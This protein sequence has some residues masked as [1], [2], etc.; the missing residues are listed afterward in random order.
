MS[1]P[2][3]FWLTITNIVLGGLVIALVVGIATG[4]L[5]EIVAKLRRRHSM[6]NELERDMRRLFGSPP[7][8]K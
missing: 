8:N 5:C 3:T 1:D 4:T 2:R 6:E 7:R